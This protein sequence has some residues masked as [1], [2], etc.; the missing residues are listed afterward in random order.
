MQDI[1]IKKLFRCEIAKKKY[2]AIKIDD[3]Y[4]FDISKLE[5][6]LEDEGLKDED[7]ID[8]DLSFLDYEDYS[9]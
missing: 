9:V 4:S 7:I 5:E 3:I 2:S 8:I 6:M 1:N